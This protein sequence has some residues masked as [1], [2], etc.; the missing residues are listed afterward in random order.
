MHADWRKS[1]CSARRHRGMPTYHTLTSLVTPLFPCAM[2]SR[3]VWTYRNFKRCTTSHFWRSFR[4]MSSACKPWVQGGNV[5][6]TS[7]KWFMWA[8]YLPSC[9]ILAGWCNGLRI[10]LS[11]WIQSWSYKSFNNLFPAGVTSILADII[12]PRSTG[13]GW[14]RSTTPTDWLRMS[15]LRQESPS[16]AWPMP[17]PRTGSKML[18]QSVSSTSHWW[19]TLW[20]NRL[21]FVW[22]RRTTLGSFRCS[23]LIIITLAWVATWQFWKAS[24]RRW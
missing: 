16:E 20:V 23:E 6:I 10:F 12:K 7:R 18:S 24:K 15:F 4:A 11:L 22:S 21:L 17:G 3:H 8:E 5:A 13:T 14:Y 19:R 1:L 2:S 9:K